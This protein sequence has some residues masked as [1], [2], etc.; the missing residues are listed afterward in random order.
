MEMLVMSV[1]RNIIDNTD[2]FFSY[3]Q[4]WKE[5]QRKG[6]KSEDN[7]CFLKLAVLIN[8]AEDLKLM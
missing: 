7:F 5:T 8:S 4:R 2:W 6:M 3:F 1:A